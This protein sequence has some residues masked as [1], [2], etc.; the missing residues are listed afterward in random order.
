[1]Y[2]LVDKMRYVKDVFREEFLKFIQTHVVKGK[3]IVQFLRDELND[4]RYFIPYIAFVFEE[5]HEFREVVNSFLPFLSEEIKIPEFYVEDKCIKCGRKVYIR[6]Y[7]K[8]VEK[9]LQN[10]GI[11]IKLM[12][13]C[14]KCIEFSGVNIR[15]MLSSI[16]EF[17]TNILL[18]RTN[19]EINR[20]Y[21]EYTRKIWDIVKDV[22]LEKGF[23]Y[24]E[25]SNE[26]E[27]IVLILFNYI[28]EFLASY[29]LCT[30]LNFAPA[31]IKFENYYI[32]ATFDKIQRCKTNYFDFVNASA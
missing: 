6:F 1:M 15:E 5:D 19:D 29:L 25:L 8:E 13:I 22:L 24:N 21:S 26:T 2:S 12:P 30:E 10:E 20:K 18:N 23:E 27:S 4:R 17:N 28:S 14:L 31:C 16:L 3:S 32:F 9:I 7:H 11:N